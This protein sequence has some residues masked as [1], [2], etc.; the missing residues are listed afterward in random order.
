M[1]VNHKKMELIK[2][3]DYEEGE[4]CWGNHDFE[5]CWD[6]DAKTRAPCVEGEV[7][8]IKKDVFKNMINKLVKL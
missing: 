3:K 1:V 5:I 6:D 2:G 8:I 4:I 7:V